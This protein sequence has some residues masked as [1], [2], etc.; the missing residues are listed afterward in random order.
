M[1]KLGSMAWTRFATSALLVLLSLEL[2]HAETI[3]VAIEDKNWTPYYVWVDGEPHGPC[4]EIAGGAIRHMG[5]EVEFVRVPWVRVLLRVQKQTVDAG[6]CGTKNNERTSYSH[7]PEEPL[8]S[9]DATLFVRADSPLQSSEITGLRGKTFGLIKGYNYGEVDKTLEK[10]GM[11]RL[12]VL[13]REGLLKNLLSGRLDTVLDSR[14]PT[15]ADARKLG[16][17]AQIRPLFPS[18][19]ETPA[20][21]FFSKRPGHDELAQ[22]FSESLKEFKA[23]DAY[24]MIRERYG[25]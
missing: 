22:R 25:F 10:Q 5:A 18:L 6:L 11:T 17:Y 23:T 1:K 19:S 16:V 3:T 14:L 12:E 7:Y 9:Y 20:Y 21:L 8:L 15:F 13:N 2:A 24:N 4:P